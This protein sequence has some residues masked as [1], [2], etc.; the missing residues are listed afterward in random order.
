[1]QLVIAGGKGW[2]EDEMY[3]TLQAT[4]MQDHVH[5]IGFA[6]AEDLPALYSGAALTAFPSALSLAGVAVP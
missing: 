6:R 1:M 2:L 5:L 4:Q 3:Q